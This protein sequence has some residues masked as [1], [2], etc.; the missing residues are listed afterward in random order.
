VQPRLNHGGHDP[1]TF[2][3]SICSA[4]SMRQY[5]IPNVANVILIP[6]VTNVYGSSYLPIQCE[7]DSEILYLVLRAINQLYKNH[8]EIY[9]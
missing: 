8:H 2:D 7:T 9:H 4:Q 3:L 6:N 1:V 5:N